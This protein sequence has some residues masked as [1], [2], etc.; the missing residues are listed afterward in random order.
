MPRDEQGP[1]V[2]QEEA[3]V[4]VNG[5]RGLYG[6]KLRVHQHINNV[7]VIFKVRKFLQGLTFLIT[8]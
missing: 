6:V 7:P 4:E 2:P 8:C 5:Q 1:G 3:L